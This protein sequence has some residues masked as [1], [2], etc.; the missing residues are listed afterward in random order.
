MKA[1]SIVSL[2]L[3]LTL[4]HTP[5]MVSAEGVD[6]PGTRTPNSPS[7]RSRTG[8]PGP[9]SRPGPGP[10]QGGDVAQDRGPEGGGGGRNAFGRSRGPEP[11]RFESAGR[12]RDRQKHLRRAVEHL[13]AAGMHEMADHVER[14]ALGVERRQRPEGR[15]EGRG[16]VPRGGLGNG[17]S[18][19][20][21][22]PHPSARPQGPGPGPGEGGGPGPAPQPQRGSGDQSRPEARNG[23]G[24]S[25]GRLP[26]PEE[27]IDTEG[28][29][30]ELGDV[31]QQ[32]QKLERELDR[33]NPPPR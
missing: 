31:R 6:A 32:L 4:L 23:G 7:D 1:P 5:R 29:R 30:R 11:S 16:R 13:H 2:S 9:D 15:D 25:E 26:R 14:M 22:A 19:G 33:V 28:L 27:R 20:T 3:M 17:P 12:D 21:G 18:M 10:G 24:P 8:G